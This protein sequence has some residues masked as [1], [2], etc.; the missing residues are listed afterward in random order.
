MVHKAGTYGQ[1]L[2][3]QLPSLCSEGRH[4]LGAPGQAC[5]GEKSLS[6]PPVPASAEGCVESHGAPEKIRLNASALLDPSSLFVRLSAGTPIITFKTLVDSGSTHSYLDFNFVQ[7]NNLKTRPVTP[8]PLYLFDGSCNSHITLAC[9][10]PIRFPCNT[11]IEVTF[12]DN[13][14]F[15]LFGCPG[16]RLAYPPQSID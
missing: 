8:V 4:H 6:S 10:L 7:S 3:S 5:R 16:T 1:R 12:R 2:S 11:M 14:R 13:F 9:D 15:E